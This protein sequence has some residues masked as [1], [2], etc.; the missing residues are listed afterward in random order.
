MPY[1]RIEKLKVLPVNPN[2]LKIL[3]ED[4]SLF[5]ANAKQVYLIISM[6][7]ISDISVCVWADA[8]PKA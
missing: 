8:K 2:F 6:S 1:F 4:Q 3:F 7:S 5:V